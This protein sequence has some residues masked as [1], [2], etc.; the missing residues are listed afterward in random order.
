MGL[1]RAIFEPL[2]GVELEW[3]ISA[4]CAGGLDP[5]QF[6]LEERRST[7]IAGGGVQ[8][9]HKLVSVKWLATGVQRQ[10]SNG[11]GGGWPFEFEHDLRAG[12]YASA[13]PTAPAAA[14]GARE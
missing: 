12:L 7:F 4:I 11:R 14:S 9:V 5:S 6:L 1:R 10:Y 2:Q 8:V 13:W 3:A